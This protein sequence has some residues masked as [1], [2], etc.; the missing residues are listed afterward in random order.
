MPFARAFN[1]GAGRVRG[2]AGRPGPAAGDR[3]PGPCPCRPARSR[4][5]AGLVAR[6]A[7]RASHVPARLVGRGAR[8]AWSAS[9]VMWA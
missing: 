5:G 6:R 9:G 8:R 1:P 3:T 4:G 2:S 7:R